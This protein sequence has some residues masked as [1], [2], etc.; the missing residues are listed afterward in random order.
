MSIP[1]R[2]HNS[3]KKLFY[4]SPNLSAHAARVIRSL[5]LFNVFTNRRLTDSGS[6]RGDLAKSLGDSFKAAPIDQFRFFQWATACS[7]KCFLNHLIG[8][9][10]RIQENIFML[11]IVS[12]PKISVSRR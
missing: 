2:I 6:S 10:P 8:G 4:A 9:I 7:G 5:L 1:N 12:V 11:S 3:Q